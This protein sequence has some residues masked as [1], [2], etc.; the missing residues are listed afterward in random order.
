MMTNSIAVICITIPTE[1]ILNSDIQFH[2][3]H[4]KRKSQMENLKPLHRLLQIRKIY[5]VIEIKN[6]LI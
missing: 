4:S 3:G 1:N 2:N 5:T 6:C